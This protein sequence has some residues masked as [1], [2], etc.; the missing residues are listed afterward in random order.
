MATLTRSLR[1][2]RK[3]SEA[4][5]TLE[6]LFQLATMMALQHRPVAGVVAARSC[7]GRGT[8]RST[9]VEARS[10]RYVGARSGDAG[11][12]LCTYRGP[13]MRRTN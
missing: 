10:C 4:G 12:A 5:V 9:A 3:S 7:W 1:A 2:A 11:E 8:L 6:M 13:G